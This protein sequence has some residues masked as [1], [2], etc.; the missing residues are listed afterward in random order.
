[1]CQTFIEQLTGPKAQ[2]R[3][4]ALNAVL[5]NVL[6]LF[7][8]Q[9]VINNLSEIL[10]VSAAYNL[11]LFILLMRFI[12]PPSQFIP[13]SE[14]DLRSLQQRLELSLEKF[15]PNAVAICDGFDFHDRVLNSVLGSYDGNVYPR[16]FDAAKRSTMNQKPVQ[17]SFEQYLKPLMKASL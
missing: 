5:E 17:R 1:M 10:R 9:T 11:L 7:L 12:R 2:Q 4:Q 16:I 14:S 8:V 15:R 13:L 3:S 6:E